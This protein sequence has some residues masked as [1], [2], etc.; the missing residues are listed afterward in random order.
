M[1]FCTKKASKYK[2]G[3]TLLIYYT[4]TNL[5]GNK[6]NLKDLPFPVQPLTNVHMRCPIHQKVC[7][8]PSSLPKNLKLYMK[9]FSAEKWLSLFFY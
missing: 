6:M 3:G 2:I 7:E 1:Q 4:C 9:V 8:I 5:F